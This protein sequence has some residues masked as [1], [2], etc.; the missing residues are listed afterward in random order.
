LGEHAAECAA[1]SAFYDVVPV[2]KVEGLLPDATAAAI[3]AAAI[4][5]SPI[6]TSTGT[7][8]IWACLTPAG[9]PELK[10]S[11]VATPDA[12]KEMTATIAVALFQIDIPNPPK[13]AACAGASAKN[14]MTLAI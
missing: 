6:H 4:P 5:A 2:V 9:L 11:A 3:P 7:E 12:T 10:G 14:Q 1:P 13:Y 8:S